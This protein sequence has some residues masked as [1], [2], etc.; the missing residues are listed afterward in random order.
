MLRHLD[1]VL[2]PIPYLDHEAR[3]GDEERVLSDGGSNEIVSV[4]AASRC[5]K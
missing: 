4:W 5:E 1:Q 3:E 2:V